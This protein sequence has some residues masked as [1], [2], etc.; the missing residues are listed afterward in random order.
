MNNKIHNDK[1]Y[2]CGQT[3]TAEARKHLEKIGG[4]LKSPEEIQAEK[5]ARTKEFNNQVEQKVQAILKEKE[6]SRRNP[7]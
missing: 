4:L 1:C 7:S 3:L 6:N 2:H 5:D